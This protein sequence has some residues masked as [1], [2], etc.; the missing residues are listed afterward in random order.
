MADIRIRLVSETRLPA[1]ESRRYAAVYEWQV[2]RWWGLVASGR[3]DTK[4]R[5]EWAAKR[6][7]EG[8]GDAKGKN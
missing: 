7:A 8:A 2:W 6:A 5:A 1:T 4:L 3:T